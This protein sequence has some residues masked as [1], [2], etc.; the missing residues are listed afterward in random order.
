MRNAWLQDNRPVMVGMIAASPDGEGFNA[1]F[2][3]FSIKHLPDLRRAKWQ[4][5][6]AQN[7]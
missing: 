1:Y 4:K 5:E 6:D 2:E 3:H 7:H